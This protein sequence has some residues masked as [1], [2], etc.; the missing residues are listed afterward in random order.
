MS[1]FENSNNNATEATQK[2]EKL[3]IENLKG[4]I[5]Y[6]GPLIILF[7]VIRL[8]FFYSFFGV[9]IVNYLE[10]SE[11]LTSF[12]DVLVIAIIFVTFIIGMLLPSLFDPILIGNETKNLPKPRKQ[13]GIW[14]IVAFAICMLVALLHFIFVGSGKHIQ[15]YRVY[16]YCLFFAIA[17]TIAGLSL[18]KPSNKTTF[19]KPTLWG[20]MIFSFIFL[21]IIFGTY[22]NFRSIRIDRSN[23]NIR[24]TVDTLQLK[25]DSF[26]YYI[27]NTKNYLFYYD[28]SAR[29]TYVYPMSRVKDISFDIPYTP[30][31]KREL[32]EKKSHDSIALH[33]N[34]G[35]SKVDSVSLKK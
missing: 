29:R 24:V 8:I 25:N 1:S 19:L 32:E 5:P 22:L 9:K 16:S 23:I 15:T 18:I 33:R 28:D 4:F 12:L 27:G 35:Q 13:K 6:I 3:Y 21:A 34:K 11:I 14:G 31:E 26:H 10:L 20:L 17:T 30:K 2:N 7:G